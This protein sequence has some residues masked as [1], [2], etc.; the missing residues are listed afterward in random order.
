MYGSTYSIF[1]LVYSQVFSSNFFE[2][3]VDSWTVTL[4]AECGVGGREGG[5]AVLVVG[6]KRQADRLH[7]QRV[8]GCRKKIALLQSR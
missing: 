7:L 1:W 8:G 5:Q 4:H 3:L 6:D 2:M